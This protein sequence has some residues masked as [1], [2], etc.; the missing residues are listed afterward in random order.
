VGTD[1]ADFLF[2]CCFG[3]KSNG[4]SIFLCYLR[5]DDPSW[6]PA[7]DAQAVDRAFR[8][9]QTKNVVIYR[10]ITC[11]TVEE[12]IYRRQIFKDSITR[13][14]TGGTKD[15]F[16]SEESQWRNGSTSVSNAGGLGF[17]PRQ[18][19]GVLSSYEAPNNFGLVTLTS[20]G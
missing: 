7:T 16:R 1:D 9:G 15:P 17:E 12:K 2:A 20:F 13:Q 8:I 10:L 6:N 19:Q 3:F 11:G 14:T 5:A 4:F 18:G